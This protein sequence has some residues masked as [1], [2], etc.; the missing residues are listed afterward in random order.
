LSFEALEFISVYRGRAQV[1]YVIVRNEWLEATYKA[2]ISESDPPTNQILVLV[3]V[4]CH[5]QFF[6]NARV[7]PAN[8]CE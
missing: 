4:R 8:V 1:P 2:G 7:C 6:E 5:V 3:G